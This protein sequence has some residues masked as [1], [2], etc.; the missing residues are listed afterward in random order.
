TQ[1][2]PYL[3]ELKRGKIDIS[4]LTF[5]PGW[6]H[7]WSEAE[8]ERWNSALLEQGIDWRALRYHKWPSVPATL[9]DIVVGG[10]VAARG[11]RRE[12]IDVFHARAHL[13][14]AM[15]MIARW[16]VKGKIVFDLRGLVADEYVDAGIWSEGS[17][18]FRFF[19]WFERRAIRRADQIVVLTKRMHHFLVE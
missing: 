11:A 12:K 19:K 14:M 18:V 17:L 13:A 7:S 4:L 10:F 8:R 16:M 3:R 6:P 2:L 9:Y 1:V 15:A 5:E